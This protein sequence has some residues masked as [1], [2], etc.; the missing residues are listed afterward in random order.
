LLLPELLKNSLYNRIRD[1]QCPAKGSEGNSAMLAQI[2]EDEVNQDGGWYSE[3]VNSLW[4]FGNRAKGSDGPERLSYVLSGHERPSSGNRLGQTRS[5]C[6]G[7]GG[8]AW[9]TQTAR[10]RQEELIA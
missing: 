8:V 4:R 9:P 1:L 2:A 3:I 7:L 6:K 10:I 5:K